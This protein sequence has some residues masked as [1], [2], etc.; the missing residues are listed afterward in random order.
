MNVTDAAL[1][2]DPELVWW[3]SVD[4]YLGHLGSS[5]ARSPWTRI[6][7]VV[8]GLCVSILSLEDV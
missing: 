6:R 7:A 3:V 4:N 8:G 2:M 5:C 1:E